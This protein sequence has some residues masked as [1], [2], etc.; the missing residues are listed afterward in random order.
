MFTRGAQPTP[1]AWLQHAVSEFT[2]DGRRLVVDRVAGEMFFAE[3]C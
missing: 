2:G 3:G 1:S